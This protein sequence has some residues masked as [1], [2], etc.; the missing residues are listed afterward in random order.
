MDANRFDTLIRAFSAVGSRRRAL[1]LTL[2]GITG[3]RGLLAIEAVEAHNAAKRCKKKSGKRKKRCLKKARKHNARH[4]TDGGGG[5]GGGGAGTG[6]TGGG[7]TGS[8]DP[9]G[10]QS[11]T[12]DPKPVQIGLS[13]VGNVRLSSPAVGET[14]VMLAVDK[15]NA[16]VPSDVTIA[17]G[18][19]TSEDFPVTGIDP[20]S[21]DPVTLSAT[22]GSVTV[23]DQ[24]HVV[25]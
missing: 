3:L 12:V 18:Q 14:V 24:F 23:T 7:G 17:D 13:S 11:V 22:L 4:T 5:G 15:D 16:D 8:D 9:P 19:T 1:L 20:T 25:A 21:G 10:L 2:G 6:G